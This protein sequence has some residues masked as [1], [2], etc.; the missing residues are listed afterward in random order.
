MPYARSNS[1]ALVSDGVR[2]PLASSLA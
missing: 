1:T 2:F